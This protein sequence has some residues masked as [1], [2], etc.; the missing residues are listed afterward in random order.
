VAQAELNTILRDL[1]REHPRDYPRDAGL[2]VQPLDE[3][4][5]GRVRTVL[6]VL[7]AAVGLVLLITCANVA[8]L[9]L[10]R[11][12]ARA[13][14]MAVRAAL[15]GGRFRLVRQV[16][17]ESLALSSFGGLIG[18][19][20]A[21]AATLVLAILA[22]SE[23][24]RA[25]EI[26]MDTYV[27]LFALMTSVLTGAVFSAAPALRA[28]HLD[29]NEI[30]RGS[31][32]VSGGRSS[33]RARKAL[34]IA[35]IA[36]AFVLAMGAGLLARSLNKLM[37]VKAGYDPHNILTMTAL[38]Y[39]H[40]PE[41]QLRHY[42]EIV[43]RVRSIPGAEGAAMVSSVP[44]SSPVQN[45]VF[46][47][48]RAT[49]DAE[50]PVLD[51]Y[52]ATADY[53]RLMRIPLILGR[54]FNVLDQPHTLPV[55]VLSE[56][57][58][59]LLFPNG[60]PIGKR[61]RSG[62]RDGDGRDDWITVIGVVGDVWQHGMDDGPSAGAYL[63]QSQHLDFYY[64]L[65]VR[66]AGDPWRIYPEV[67]RAMREI[68]PNQ[69]LFHVQPMEDYV[70]K[71]LADRISALSLIALLGSLALALAAVG[72]Y[73][74]VSYTVSL[75]TREIGIRMAL[76]ADRSAVLGLVMRDVLTMLSWGLA[77][78]LL[79][80]LPL[81]RYL[82]HLLYAVNTTDI[83]ATVTAALT[84]AG[85]ALAAGFVPCVHALGISPSSALRYS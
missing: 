24:P 77:F 35:Q 46:V 20:L 63:P 80:A 53:F 84:L 82:A 55:A 17:T 39:D 54:S 4:L 14:E 15:G 68:D 78:G 76:G 18:L 40:T 27:L 66:T 5:T 3:K 75:R 29:L 69:A 57:G 73:G 70:T 9:L 50:A 30:L 74:V 10:T 64:R 48:G 31:R 72:I 26:R 83:V 44:L 1:L 49:I 41:Q 71:S 81:M 22:P 8:G 34:V 62:G 11:A 58:A 38:I 47:E 25:D 28:A 52:F 37:H 32:E 33:S 79:T 16:F 13:T 7:L 12:N 85:V 21:W 65:L 36:C 2:L 60:D 51:Q 19:L 45:S 59:H 56:S 6:R 42:Q 23:I 43:E 61:V 67:R